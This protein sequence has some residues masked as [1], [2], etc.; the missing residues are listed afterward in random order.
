MLK[1]NFKDEIQSNGKRLYNIIDDATNHIIQ[2][3]CILERS[4]VN[5]EEGTKIN[6]F[7]MKQ[8]IDEI[9]KNTPVGVIHAY[10]G[11][12]APSGYLLCQGQ[13]VSRTVYADL[14]RVIGTSYGIGDGSTTF[15]LP[16]LRGRVV[17]GLKD[18]D[19][20]FNTLAKKAGSKTHTLT[21]NEMP[22]HTHKQNAHKHTSGGSSS[23]TGSHTHTATSN[24]TGA[25]THTVSGTAASA[26]THQHDSTFNMGYNV[27][28][29]GAAF[30]KAYK[31]TT[32]NGTVADDG[33]H[34]H[35]VSGTA[36]SA[37]SHSHTI[38]V[39]SGGAH[40]HT[41]TVSVD[42]TTAVNQATG[43]GEAHNNMQP[44]LVMNY[45]IK[46]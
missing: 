44:Y 30:A 31:S 8:I 35:K 22:S 26:G 34:T 7:M 21:V 17:V 16:D 19:S 32:W 24:S 18:D 10:A 41:I 1:M 11:L 9:N 40:S 13:Q 2:Q 5:D 37:G 14:F 36:A 15:H 6:A 4:N 45:I 3:N 12:H 20:D 39:N 25:H 23:S 28:A 27:H 29:D 46:Y 42:N 43:G 38:T 33:A